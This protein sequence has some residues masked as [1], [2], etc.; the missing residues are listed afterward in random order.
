[1]RLPKIRDKIGVLKPLTGPHGEQG[2]IFWVNNIMLYKQSK[3]P[4]EA[5]VFLQWWSEHEKDLWTKGHV[6]QLPVRKSFAADPYL[7]NNPETAFILSNYVPIGKNTA[8]HAAEIFPKLNDVEGE[9][10]MQ[11][12]VQNL[13]Q[14][15]DLPYLLL[16][17]SLTLICL[18]E[19]YPFLT[20]VSYSFHKGTLLSTGNFVALDNYVRLFN[21]PDFYNSLSFSF[22]FAFFNVVFSYLIGLGLALFLNLDFPGRGLC[23]VLLLIPWIVPA[24]VSIVSWKWLIADRGGLVNII[25]AAFGLGPIYFLSQSG[26]AMVAVIVIKIWRSFPFM[27]L[28]LLA[29]LQVIDRTLYEAGKLDG[30]SRWQ[31]FWHITLPHLKNISI[32]QAILMVIWSISVPKELDRAGRVDGCSRL[33]GF[34]QIVLPLSTPGIAAVA[35]FS[36]LF[37]YNEFF[38]S[39]VFLRDENRMTMPVGIQSFMQQYSTDWGSL[40]ASAALAMVPTLILFLFIQK[41][42]I[43]GAT[44]GAVKG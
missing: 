41:Y 20:G 33:R 18:I 23:R 14:G 38:I 10:V 21:S 36:F 5:K 4:A 44:A 39:S 6:T 26:W 11:T 27:M 24:V 40:M 29:Q 30:A 28:S 9:G 42:M 34:V 13:L 43:S 17:P 25:L 16:L 12:L 7:Q 8:T 32:V 19:L 2:T 22:F 31:L 1:V 35:I 3:H 37:S 15:K